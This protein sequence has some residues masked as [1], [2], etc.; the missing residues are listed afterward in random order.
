[1]AGGRR[2]VA[3]GRWKVAGDTWQLEGGCD[4]MRGRRVVPDRRVVRGKL[5]RAVAY[6]CT[7]SPCRVLQF[8]SMLVK[9]YTRR[10]CNYTRE[11]AC[12]KQQLIHD[13]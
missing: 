1:M 4:V 10:A 8:A 9:D 11:V 2:Q 13:T 12:K 6:A 7:T 5:W 3:G